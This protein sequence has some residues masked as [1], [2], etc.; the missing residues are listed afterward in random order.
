MWFS[1]FQCPCMKLFHDTQL[2]IDLQMEMVE[3][4]RQQKCSK[5]PGYGLNR[6]PT[7]AYLIKARTHDK[8]VPRNNL[9]RSRLRLSRLI[10]HLREGLPSYAAACVDNHLRRWIPADFSPWT[11]S[12]RAGRIPRARCIKSFLGHRTLGGNQPDTGLQIWLPR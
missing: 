1:V 2:M 10:N 6:K 7:S 12:A 8:V 4:C 5:N 11:T 9:L 3:D